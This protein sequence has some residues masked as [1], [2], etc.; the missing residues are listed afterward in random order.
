M[1]R[2]L[3]LGTIALL[4]FVLGT[5]LQADTLDDAIDAGVSLQ[6]NDGIYL[7][8]TQHQ[9]GVNAEG[10]AKTYGEAVQTPILWDAKFDNGGVGLTL[11]SH[12]LLSS[13]NYSTHYYNSSN[14]RSQLL[15]M[16]SNGTFITEEKALLYNDKGVIYSPSV[17]TSYQGSNF[18]NSTTT[19][20][21]IYLPEVMAREEGNPNNVKV[22]LGV[23]RNTDL[24]QLTGAQMNFKT[25]Y[26]N[27]STQT[28]GHGSSALNINGSNHWWFRTADNW[29]Y[30]SYPYSVFIFHGHDGIANSQYITTYNPSTPSG[31]PYT[32]FGVR[33][34]TNLQKTNII[35]ASEINGSLGGTPADLGNTNWNYESNTSGNRNLRLT[36][37]KNTSSDSS[38]VTPSL[39]FNTTLGPNGNQIL[40]LDD[41]PS[42]SMTAATSIEAQNQLAYKLVKNLGQTNE[43][44]VSYGEGT[45]GSSSLTTDSLEAGNYTLVVWEQQVKSAGTRLAS[46][47][48]ITTIYAIE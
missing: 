32:H 4:P 9:N 37:L 35:W 2:K 6:V 5:K 17:G 10:G 7:G 8:S 12:Y 28:G 21:L 24:R 33:P 18:T 23:N 16:L 13:S 42:I 20:D 47:P 39:N 27:G 38:L 44:L 1:K 29:K 15:A 22:N 26:K 11:W 14:I 40:F 30:S 19:N 36:L 31:S 46:Q 25:T 43:E 34:V 3:L 41:S 45:A 48:Y